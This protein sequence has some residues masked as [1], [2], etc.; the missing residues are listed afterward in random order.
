MSY[1]CLQYCVSFRCIAKWF[2]YT[3]IY[4]F[5]IFSNSFPSYVI[6]SYWLQFPVVVVLN[7]SVITNSVTPWTVAHQ[8]PP[9]VRFSQARILEWVAISFSR[10]FFPTL[11]SNSRLFHLLHWQVDPLPLHHLGRS[12]ISCTTQ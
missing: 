1:S 12:I 6:T 4:I 2:G 8:V 5:F 9:S 11:G 7:H 10:G 3:Y